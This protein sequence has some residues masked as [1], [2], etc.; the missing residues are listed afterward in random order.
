MFIVQ[1]MCGLTDVTV[2]ALW[3]SCSLQKYLEQW[4]AVLYEAGWSVLMLMKGPKIPRIELNEV[5]L[6]QHY[7]LFMHNELQY[8]W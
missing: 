2:A 8:T 5:H 1:A 4:P 6:Y 7:S 3:S